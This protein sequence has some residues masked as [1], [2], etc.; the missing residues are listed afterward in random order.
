MEN[1]DKYEV[2]GYNMR[3]IR[4]FWKSIKGSYG[5]NW[6]R[7]NENDT[8]SFYASIEK[9][10]ESI[11]MIEYMEWNVNDSI[12]DKWAR[13]IDKKTGISCEYLAGRERI[14]LGAEFEKKY[15]RRYYNYT[16]AC[17]KLNK[18]LKDKKKDM[19]GYSLPKIKKIAD[20]YGYT[21]D[22]KEE[23]KKG[24]DIAEKAVQIMKRFDDALSKEVNRIKKLDMG[25]LMEKDKKLYRLVYFIKTGKQSE[26]TGLITMEDIL[27]VME[28]TGM[29]HLD[30]YGKVELERYIKAL[31]RHLTL[32]KAVYINAVDKKIF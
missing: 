30:K 6:I 17:D 5:Q 21:K 7:G 9:S 16:R 20:E 3:V 8:S 1:L 28:R 19:P 24:I 25:Q 26:A 29:E 12:I 14:K 22:E 11:R 27:R 32:A 13:N 18:I 10:R 4:E 2:M 23:L 31:D 15:Y